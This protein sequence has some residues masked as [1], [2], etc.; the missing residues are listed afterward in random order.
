MTGLNQKARRKAEKYAV[1]WVPDELVHECQR[2][3]HKFNFA[4]RRHHCRSCGRLVCNP[5][6][7][8][9]VLFLRCSANLK[10]VCDSCA[11][12]IYMMQM[13]KDPRAVNF[14]C[15][16]LATG[17]LAPG[18]Y[19]VVVTTEAETRTARLTVVR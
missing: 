18:V 1:N 19:S 5:C 17:G 7:K 3:Q 12:V 16:G 10:R 15:P 11:D 14:T 13:Q 9:R 2:C 4:R 6:S 8:T